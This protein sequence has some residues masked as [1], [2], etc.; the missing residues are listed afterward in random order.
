MDLDHGEHGGQPWRI[1]ASIDKIERNGRCSYWFL[2]VNFKPQGVSPG[3]WTEGWGIPAGGHLPATATIDAYEEEEGESV[4]GIVGS[5]VSRVVLTLSDGRKM[6]ISPKDPSKEL[7]KRFVWLHG[8]RYF[9]SF[10]PAGE[11]VRTA[12]LLDAN[13]KVVYIAHSREGELIGNMVY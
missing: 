10:F 2:K 9:L 1:T 12:K 8:L 11:H 5:R 4:G 3:S 7:L 13:G 6:L